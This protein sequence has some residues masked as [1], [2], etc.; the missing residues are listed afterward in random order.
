M[1]RSRKLRV[2]L[3]NSYSMELVYSMF[4]KGTFPGHHLFGSPELIRDHE[5]EVIIPEHIKYPVL[6]RVGNLF[7]IEFLDQQ[8]RALMTL[9]KYDV[10]YAPYGA[11]N[12]KLIIL[13]KTIGIINKPVVILVHFPVFGRPSKNS[14]KRALVRR[15]IRNYD[16]L[17]FLSKKLEQDLIT[18][19][20]INPNHIEAHFR[21]A[22]WG[23]DLDFF[24]PFLSTDTPQHQ[25]YIISSGN[26]GR[27][28][29]VIV[30]AARSVNFKFKIYC[31]P[32]SYPSIRDIPSN[33]EILSGDFPFEQICRDYSAARIVLIPCKPGFEGPVGLTSLLEAMALGK[34]VIMTKNEYID[35]D[36][37][38]EGI[39]RDVPISDADAWVNTINSI[40]K[41][42]TLLAQMGR[43]I[44]SLAHK[45]FASGSFAGELSTTVLRA[46][47]VK[48]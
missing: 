46:C 31:K 47:K 3:I 23:V 35:I 2:L 44:L 34:P 14:I 30:E 45:K 33:V 19:Y 43:N 27:D 39:G 9:R 15:L 36:F 38:K 11:L 13:L 12:T 8:L 28:F 40:L 26:T 1:K 16:Q 20:C 37:E 17:V 22:N 10:I 7:G 42:Y 21:I 18:S 6:N 32:E 24:K 25:K 41:D 5:I 29:D 4:R 48:N